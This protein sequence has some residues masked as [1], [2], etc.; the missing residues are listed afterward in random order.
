MDSPI[1]LFDGVCR[2]CNGF[3]QFTL[4]RDPAARFRFAPLQSKTGQA[5][6]RQWNLPND[7]ST[8]V[9]VEPDRCYV[10]SAAILRVVK[11]LPGLWPLLY[12][13]MLVPQPL[14]DAVYDQIARHRYRILGREDRCRVP[15]PDARRRFL[16]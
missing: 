14:R 11:R 3:V 7:L 6:L 5:L 9:Y 13:F 1:L 16:D 10:K 15:T 8:F 2:F 12:V 4:Q